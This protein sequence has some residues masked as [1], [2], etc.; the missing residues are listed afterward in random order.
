MV[1]FNP[2]DHYF[3]RA[4]ELDY[5]AR[6]VFKLGE[7]DEKWKLIRPGQALIDL[8][9][10]PGSWS[11]FILRNWG[12]AEGLLIGVDL[13]LTEIKDRR[14]FFIQKSIEDLDPQDW[15]GCFS[16]APA[17]LT[18]VFDG[19]LSDMAPTTTG[20]KS[21]DQIKSLEL[22]KLALKMA[23]LHLKPRGFFV[24]KIFEGPETKAFVNEV[25]KHFLKVEL[26]KPQS[27]RRISKEIFLIGLEF[28]PQD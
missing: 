2:K 28:R 8:G 9:C 6:S 20:I 23:L 13:K 11:Q 27:T 15:S 22:C 7:I 19:V 12:K 1:K 14:F 16:K 4:K 26:Y 3:N 17:D 18:S 21:A 10:A 24:V 25:K 5:K